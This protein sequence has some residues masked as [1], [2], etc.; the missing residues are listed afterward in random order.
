MNNV[1]QFL[2]RFSVLVL[3]AFSMAG[4]AM[5]QQPAAIEEIGGA[6]NAQSSRTLTQKAAPVVNATAQLRSVPAGSLEDRVKRLER[7]VDN[8]ALV[9]MLRRLNEVQQENE[10][11]RSEVEE[12]NHLISG[13]KS[14]QRDIY[15]DID[16]RMQQLENDSSPMAKSSATV[17]ASS[18]TSE[19][20]EAEARKAYEQAFAILR[21]KQY[22]DAIT[23]FKT[24]VTR[25]PQS[26]FAD[27]ALYWQGEA[28]RVTRR[29]SQAVDD[30][31]TLIKMYPKS[32]KLAD[33]Y[34]KLG[35]S[36]YQLSHFS[37]AKQAFKTV[38]KKYPNSSSARL[39]KAQLKKLEKEGH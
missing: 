24:L 13:L 7:M 8:R 22:D 12:L 34:Y 33:A 10:T 23:Q 14:R 28:N 15:N 30:F 26:S 2:V 25:Y 38:R 16:R 35:I 9:G 5:A 39:S 4:S 29:F 18:P 20:G 27:N 19:S 3:I 11:L 31:N 36:H 21:K 1:N 6:S 37:E 17:G 32:A